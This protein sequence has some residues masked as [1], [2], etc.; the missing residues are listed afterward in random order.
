MAE[1][2]PSDYLGIYRLF[3]RYTAALDSRDIDTLVECFAADATL[4]SPTIGVFEGRKEIR[5]FAERFARYQEA[6]IQMRH[7]FFNLTVEVEGDHARAASYLLITHTSGGDVKLQPPGSYECALMRQGD[8]WLF[9]S[10]AVV[11][12]AEARLGKV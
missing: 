2:S 3:A 6:G 9:K 12:D 1:C 10:R 7:F 4:S 8:G 5:Q 11:M